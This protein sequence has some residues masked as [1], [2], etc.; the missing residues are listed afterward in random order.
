LGDRYDV[1]VQDSFELKPMHRGAVPA[2]V[3]KAEHYRLLNDPR[4]AESICLDVLAIDPENQKALVILVLSLSDQLERRKDAGVK[5]ARE[6]LAR[7]KDPYQRVYFDGLVC[8]RR[9]YT[10]LATR[11]PGSGAAAHAWF[12]QA[13]DRYEE[14]ERIRPPDNDEAILR[15]NSVV[16]MLGRHPEIRPDPEGPAPVHMLE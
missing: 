5:Q 11:H 3:A 6:Y 16:R 12:R 8:E 14:A 13:M 9:A 4:Q 10:V 7:V 2:A 1:A 15:W